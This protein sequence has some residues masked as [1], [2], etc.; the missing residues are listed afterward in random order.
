MKKQKKK[1][2]KQSKIKRTPCPKCGK[3]ESHY[4]PPSFGDPGFYL[5]EV[6]KPASDFKI[7]VAICEDC[8]KIKK[9]TFKKGEDFRDTWCMICKKVVTWRKL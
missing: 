8:G 1:V 9:L 4:L 7:V 5:C 6:E 2:K 3:W